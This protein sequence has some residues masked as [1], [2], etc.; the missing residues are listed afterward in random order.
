MAN[1]KKRSAWSLGITKVK[2]GAGAAATAIKGF[3]SK[4]APFTDREVPLHDTALQSLQGT[5]LQSLQG[6]ASQSLQGTGCKTRIVTDIIFTVF[7]LMCVWYFI[8]QYRIPSS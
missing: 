7:V 1:V 8:N 5:A 4:F 2:T 3:F 6:T